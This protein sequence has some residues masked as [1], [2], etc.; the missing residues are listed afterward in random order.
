M[1]TQ[2]RKVCH[3]GIM[4]D[5]RLL[6]GEKI[7]MTQVFGENRELVPVTVV[8]IFPLFVSQIKEVSRDGYSAIQ[9]AYGERKIKN[10][11]DAILGHLRAAGLE[12]CCGF[13]EFRVEDSEG[14]SL[15]DRLDSSMF[16]VG[17]FIDVIGETKGHGF[18]GVMRRHGF[19]GGPAGHGSMFH[20]RGGSFGCREWPGRVYKGRKMPGHDGSAMRTVQNLRIVDILSD[21][22]VILLGGSVPGYKGGMVILRKAKKA[23]KEVQ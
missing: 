14:Y 1:Q 3:L 22:S 20:R 18:Q 7:G 12:S 6:L 16:S 9:V 15:G 17:E 2:G 5:N 8:K 19:S 13:R 10:V 21:E 4:R 11:S 23:Q